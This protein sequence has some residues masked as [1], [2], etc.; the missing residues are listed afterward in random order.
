MKS[1][2]LCDNAE[3]DKILPLC[4]KYHAGIEIQ[5]FYDP[6]RTGETEALLSYYEKNLPEGI[7]KHFHAPFW[8]LCLGSANRKIVE[9]TRFY[10]DYAYETAERL[11]AESITVHEGFIPFTS[12]PAG[13]IRRATEFWQDFFASHPGW[14]RMYMENQVETDP[15]TMLGTVDNLKNDRLGINLDIGHAYCVNGLPVL[16]WIR[17]LQGRIRYVHLHQNYGKK[18]EH[19]SLRQGNMPIHE[20]LDALNRYAPDAVWALESNRPEDVEDSILFLR[21]NGYLG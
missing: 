13:W 11:G 8:D 9:V 3:P 4:R 20:I 10:F 2:V 7:E 5:G 14:I 21:E 18:D 15:E 12:Y 19:L 6:N 16:E 1:L 17:K